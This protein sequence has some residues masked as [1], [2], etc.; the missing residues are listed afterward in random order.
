M[1]KFD[2]D[3]L[4]DRHN[5]GCIKFDALTQFFGRPDLTPLWVADMDFPVHPAITEALMRHTAHPVYGY[6]AIAESYYQS[7]IDW[8]SHRHGFN[9]RREDLAYI[10]GVVKGIG[11]AVNFFTDR[12]DGIVIQPPVYPP[13]RRLVEGNGRRLLTNPL[14]YDPSIGH[15]TMDFEGLQHII[16][17]EH[18]RM[19][20]LCNPHNPGGR[21]WSMAELHR[22]AEICSAAGMIV[23]SDE[24]H[25]DL[26]LDGRT[27]IP[28]ADVSPEA[29][30][31]TVT[32]GAPS[33]TF[34]IPGLVSSW[35]VV[36][37]PELRRPFFDWLETNE[38]STPTNVAAIGAEA[39]YRNAEEW[40]DAVLVYIRENIDRVCEFLAERMPQ[41]RIIRPE[42]SFLMWLD[43]RA[44]GYSCEEIN[45]RLIDR[46]HL[47]LN[48]GESFGDEG[49][50]FVRLNVATQRATLTKALERFAMAMQ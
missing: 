21:Q 28:F 10:P 2:F 34:N 12:G 14:V 46:G 25:A 38:F 18:P 32:L 3:S 43:C 15:Y 20:I 40:L 19:L 17:T 9:I 42:A 7:V 37:N 13:F 4:I 23:V 16:D 22:L 35:A 39:A 44:L 5:T 27:H 24:I 50:G 49:R 11:L 8:L 29:A 36:L 33:K 1:K 26:M 47:A 31:I 6:P 45:S 30:A 48:P 41:V